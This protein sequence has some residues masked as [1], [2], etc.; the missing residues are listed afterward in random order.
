[1]ADNLP[2]I[3][4]L[5]PTYDPGYAAVLARQQKLSDML[6][7]QSS[8]PLQG[9]MVSNHYVAPSWTQGLAKMLQAYAGTKMGNETASKLANMQAG[10]FRNAI[11]SLTQGQSQT[12][13]GANSTALAAGAAGQNPLQSAPSM[14]N[15]SPPPASMTPSQV[16]VGPT[17]ANA[18][19]AKALQ[20]Q[21]QPAQDQTIQ[22]PGVLG[23]IPPALLGASLS[24]IIPES[25]MSTALSPYQATDATKMAMASGSDPMQANK[26]ALFKNNYVP[27]IALKQGNTILD[28]RTQQPIFTSPDMD[29]GAM[30]KWNNG[31]PSAY[32]IPGMTQIQGDLARAKAG[33]SAHYQFAP[34][35]Y[36]NNNQPLPAQTV[37]EAVDGGRGSGLTNNP[38]QQGVL[39]QM[40][41]ES[42][43]APSWTP[44]WKGN[45]IGQSPQERGTLVPQLGAEAYQNKTATA[46]GDR[47][48]NLISQAADSPTRVNVLDNIINLSKGGVPTGPTQEWRNQFKGVAADS[49]GIKSW[50]GD[51]TGFQEMK[52]FLAQNGQRAWTAAG[53]TGTDAQLEAALHAN[54]NDKMF[55][56]AIQTMANWAK[57]GEMALQAK[58][59]AMQGLG[60]NNPQAQAQFEAS[61]RQALDP[62]IYQM[63]LMSPQE[64]QDFVKNLKTNNPADYQ[65][66]IIKA[67]KLKQM[68]GL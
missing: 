38:S 46:A 58:A 44:S 5:D 3:T 63:K 42:L 39:G 51:V 32:Q 54:P 15:G 49:L 65:S 59:N 9:S 48:N 17:P 33:G 10:A 2:I 18:A 68:G 40:G 25:V 62:R 43:P 35:T 14:S 13:P 55:P 41:N 67:Q 60:I 53:G 45:P 26:D 16:N 36:D 4:A 34:Q 20:A 11:S 56:Q 22:R 31:Q 24:G 57:A 23:N 21:G 37:S 29:S 52:K 27:P 1:M 6:L 7:Q 47:A 50:Q 64:A 12:V 19:L 66:L 28:P 8:D 30:I 61:W